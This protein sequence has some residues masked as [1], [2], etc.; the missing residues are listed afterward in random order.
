MQRPPQDPEQQD[1]EE[2]KPDGT[3][4]D[5]PASLK[6][7][8]VARD[9]FCNYY[10]NE[11]QRLRLLTALKERVASNGDPKP[12]WGVTFTSD[13]GSQLAGEL[14]IAASAVG[15]NL[16][17]R[18]F[19][20]STTDPQIDEESPQ[21]PG[22]LIAMN[23]VRRLLSCDAAEFTEQQAA[24]RTFHLPL[25]KDVDVLL[26]R[27][28]VRT[29]RWY[30]DESSTL[31]VAVDLEYAQGIDD[32]RLL[33]ADWADRNGVVFPGRIGL[34]SGIQEDVRWLNI[35]NVTVNKSAAP[36]KTKP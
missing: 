31:P 5:V 19:L 29:C 7:L 28:G 14:T 21:L 16:N 27:E 9:G 2:I 26:T 23:Q 17:N 13:P 4:E 22:L 33:F 3:A 30:F 8:F 11:I 24:G 12:V 32:A 20:Q 18:P 6:S 36:E 35:D 10:F 15:M 25:K 1:S 34:I